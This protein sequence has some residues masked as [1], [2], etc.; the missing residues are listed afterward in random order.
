[1]V[2]NA[3]LNLPF[4]GGVRLSYPAGHSTKRHEP[5]M[6]DRNQPEDH[7]SPQE[8]RD[9][10]AQ[11]IKDSAKAHEL[12]VKEATAFVTAYGSGEITA[13][14]AMRRMHEYDRRWG[15]ALFGT[16]AG[17]N[18]TDQAIV[19]RIDR[20]RA[21]TASRSGGQFH[22]RINRTPPENIR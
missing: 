9:W 16:N 6:D 2:L 13:N 20:A 12:R 15:E 4:D 17:N 21:E 3:H 19:E 10:L 11:E 22:P 5:G 1:M 8:M 7:L 14:E 18:V